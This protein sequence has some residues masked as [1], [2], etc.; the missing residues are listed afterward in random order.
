MPENIEETNLR[1]IRHWGIQQFIGGTLAQ[2]VEAVFAFPEEY[3]CRTRYSTRI[4][5]E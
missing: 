3:A 5:E 4:L 2:L 1:E